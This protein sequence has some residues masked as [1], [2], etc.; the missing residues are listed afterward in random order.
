MNRAKEVETLTNKAWF[1]SKRGGVEEQRRKET[2]PRTFTE[3]DLRWRGYS[4]SPGKK[5][6]PE[7][8]REVG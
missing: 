8:G 1:K 5:P 4:W 7:K 3:P 6:E 2:A